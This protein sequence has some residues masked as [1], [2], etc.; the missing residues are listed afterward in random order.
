VRV[1]RSAGAIV[2]HEGRLLRPAQDCS[3]RYG[4]ALVWNEIEALD[5]RDYRERTLG[6]LDARGIPGADGVHHYHRAGAW[7]A[8]DV[9]RQSP[10]ATFAAPAGR[11]AAGLLRPV[12]LR[13]RE[14]PA[15]EP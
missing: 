11:D 14:Q 8:I 4:R 2:A 9:R 10:A 5:E 6:R 3:V 1:S 12:D 7:E 13:G 15:R